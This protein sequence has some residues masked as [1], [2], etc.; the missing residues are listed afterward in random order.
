[1]NDSE[2]ILKEI[3]HRAVTFT[4]DDIEKD[5]LELNKA[6]SQGYFIHDYVRTETGIVYVLTKWEKNQDG[7][8][9]NFGKTSLENNSLKECYSIFR[10]ATKN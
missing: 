10:E 4:P 2:N 3:I 9:N 5:T 1:M 8:E 6:I 7:T